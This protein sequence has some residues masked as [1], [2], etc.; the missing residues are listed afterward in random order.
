MRYAR[1][2]L[3]LLVILTCCLI[4]GRAEAG[5]GRESDRQT[6]PFT[7]QRGNYFSWAAP[8]GWKS[9]ETMNGLTLTSPAGDESV[10]YAIPS[11]YPFKA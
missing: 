3:I 1:R 8:T 7:S 5:S 6:L 10:M 9:S 11:R 4:A 2:S